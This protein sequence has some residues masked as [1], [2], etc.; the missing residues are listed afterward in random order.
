MSTIWVSYARIEEIDGGIYQ[1][2]I[3]N[4]KTYFF[5]LDDADMHM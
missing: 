3:V 4:H 2:E 5:S 1:H